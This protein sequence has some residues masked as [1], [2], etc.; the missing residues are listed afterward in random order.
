VIPLIFTFFALI[1][2]FVVYPKLYLAVLWLLLGCVF[3]GQMLA[4]MRGALRQADRPPYWTED[5]L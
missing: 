5:E 1:A 2:L 4:D 3:L